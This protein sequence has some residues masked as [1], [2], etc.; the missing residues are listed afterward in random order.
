MKNSAHYSETKRS[1]RAASYALHQGK[2][3]KDLIDTAIYLICKKDKIIRKES[4]DN[5]KNLLDELNLLRTMIDKNWGRLIGSLALKNLNINKSRNQIKKLLPLTEDVMKLRKYCIEKAEN[6][7]GQLKIK[8]NILQYRVLVEATF[9]LV[10]LHNRRRV[11]DIQY[12]ELSDVTKMDTTSEHS[13]EI[14]Q[15]LS[16]TERMLTKLYKKIHTIGKGSKDL[17]VLVPRDI[18][19]FVNT[20]LTE[21]S[22]YIESSNKYFFANCNLKDEWINGCYTQN[23]Y[24]KECGAKLPHLIRSSRLR[25]HIATMMQ[26]MDLRENEISQVALFMGHTEKTHREFYRLPKDVLMIAKVSKILLKLEKG[27]LLNCKNKSM[28]EIDI[29]E[30]VISNS[31]SEEENESSKNFDIPIIS[32]GMLV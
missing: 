19:K 25:K 20:L 1:Y 2:T 22:K 27:E 23:K 28:D 4:L 17:L 31:S 26:L 12:I 9:M 29:D 13:D 24:S 21:R 16:P 10:L 8:T 18:Y 7:V 32:H 11:G 15:A 14:L 6:A 30:P 3:L 5:A